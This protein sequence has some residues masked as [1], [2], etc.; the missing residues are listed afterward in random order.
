MNR[1]FFLINLVLLVII[2]FLC[3]RFYNVWAKP[4]DIPAQI[5]QQESIMDMKSLIDKKKSDKAAYYVIVRKDLFRPSRSAS[6]LNKTSKLLSL[7]ETPKLFGTIIMSNDKSAILEDP[8]TKTTKLYHINDSVA[9][10]IVTDIQVDKVVLLRGTEKIEVYLRDAKKFKLPRPQ[11]K[12]PKTPR[13]PQRS[14]PTRLQ[15]QKP[16][17]PPQSHN[18]SKRLFAWKGLYFQITEGNSIR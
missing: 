9:G 2:G 14:R 8:N 13:K 11:M 18:D 15:P 10:F 16:K 5:S 17:I 1:R 3:F 4:L 12:R 6:Q 7:K